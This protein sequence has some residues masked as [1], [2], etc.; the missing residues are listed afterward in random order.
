MRMDTQENHLVLQVGRK[1]SELSSIPVCH[2][3]G[4]IFKCFR[5]RL[6][7]SGAMSQQVMLDHRCRASVFVWKVCMGRACAAFP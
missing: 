6:S 2:R 1:D 7:F 5:A 3:I 4:S